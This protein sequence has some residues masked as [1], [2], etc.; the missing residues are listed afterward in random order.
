MSELSL[1]KGK[2]LQ[3]TY[4]GILMHLL[5]ESITS[6][7]SLRDKPELTIV[8]VSRRRLFIDSLMKASVCVGFK[9]LHT[10]KKK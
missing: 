5:R 6:N 3:Y 1:S 7:F 8:Y 4:I 9:A 10:L 2:S